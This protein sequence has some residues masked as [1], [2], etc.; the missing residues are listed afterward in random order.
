MTEIDRL[1]NKGRIVERYAEA[2]RNLT[3]HREEVRFLAHVF[4]RLYQALNQQ[5][6]SVTIRHWETV[7]SDLK[8]QGFEWSKLTLEN[9][10]TL[11]GDL[12][13]AETEEATA[14]QEKIDAG[15]I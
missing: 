13:K 6:V 15:I 11:L 10:S 14:K 12:G 7:T 3:E 8:K 9:L 5:S 1:A 2:K 4:E